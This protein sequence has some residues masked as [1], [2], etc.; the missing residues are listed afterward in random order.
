MRS[1]VLVSSN[2][3]HVQTRHVPFE[4]LALTCANAVS[5]YHMIRQTMPERRDL[6]Y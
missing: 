4:L 3:G 6:K 1:K 5:T 2:E